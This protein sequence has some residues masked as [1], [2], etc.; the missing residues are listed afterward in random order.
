MVETTSAKEVPVN[1]M[2]ELHIAILA[3]QQV[4]GID[5]DLVR[6]G[7]AAHHVEVTEGNSIKPLSE[8][9][10]NAR[11]PDGSQEEIEAIQRASTIAFICEDFRQSHKAAQ[12]FKADI[13]F[14]SAGGV[15][16]PDNIRREAM[17]NL[18]VA[19]HRV[20]PQATFKFAYH[21]EIC[22]GAN[23]FTGKKMEHIYKEQGPEAEFEKMT[24]F[25]H[26]FVSR[27][28][29]SG[30]P[31]DRIELHAV[32]LHHGHAPEGRSHLIKEIQ[33]IHHT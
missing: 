18:A 13:V 28:I 3:V 1:P 2:E 22:G 27:T 31:N 4:F 29:K 16:Q 5:A 23:H 8:G 19:M 24:Q 30:V 10:Y 9:N 17:V 20:N 7:A 33:R 6:P 32:T 21:T 26:E 12:E 14:A 11:I 15:V 25:A